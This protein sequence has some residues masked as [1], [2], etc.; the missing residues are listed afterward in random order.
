MKSPAVLVT[1]AG[2][3]LGSLFARHM[4][5]LGYDLALHCNSSLDKA[6]QLAQALQSG[7]SQCEIFVQDFSEAFEV[8]SFVANVQARFPRLA[9]IIN[10]A[11]AYEPALAQNTSRELLESQFRVNFVTP[12]LLAGSFARRVGSG[13][14]INILDNKIAYHQ[15]QYAAYLLSKKSLADFT[16][17]AALEFAP[18]IRVN[19][20]SPGV[21]LPGET[22]G[23]DYLSW[24][25]DG[26][27]LKKKGSDVQLMAALDYLLNNDFVTGQILFVDGGESLNQVGRNSENYKDQQ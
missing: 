18:H 21:T 16:K 4:A 11:S 14:I 2:T 6:R 23:N 8:D 22:R 27:P 12:F 15:F 24:R 19:G 13:H 20:I 3:R 25:I 7:G 9:C 17:M 26:I 10:N 5:T 1:G